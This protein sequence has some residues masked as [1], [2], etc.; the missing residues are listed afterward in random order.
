[1]SSW[2]SC[3]A[4]RPVSDQVHQPALGDT[5]EY[6][7]QCVLAAR[8]ELAQVA[9]GDVVALRS[10]QA[11]LDEASAKLYDATGREAATG[12]AAPSAS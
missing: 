10:L 8:Q 3:S 11:A 9:V 5:V 4:G 7:L 2:A 6:A 12:S 1:M